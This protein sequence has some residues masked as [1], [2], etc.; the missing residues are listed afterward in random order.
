MKELRVFY[1]YQFFCNPLHCRGLSV[2]RIKILE[3]CL[4]APKEALNFFWLGKEPGK[5]LEDLTKQ[6]VHRIIFRSH[7]NFSN[8]LSTDGH[9]HLIHKKCQSNPKRFLFITIK[10]VKPAFTWARVSPLFGAM[11]FYLP[12]VLK[13]SKWLHNWF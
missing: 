3:L 13:G 7:H 2:Q 5:K 6:V 8:C 1:F 12:T 11:I 10:A 4:K 9:C